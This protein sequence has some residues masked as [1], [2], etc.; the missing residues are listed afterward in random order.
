MKK[1][2]RRPAFWIVVV[3]VIFVIYKAPTDVSAILRLVGQILVAIINGLGAFL[4]AL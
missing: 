3:I 4:R 2:L 1:L